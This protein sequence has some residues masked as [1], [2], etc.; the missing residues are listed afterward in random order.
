MALKFLHDREQFDNEKRA[1]EVDGT[2]GVLV[3]LYENGSFDGELSAD[4][5]RRLRATFPGKFGD[6]ETVFVLC[7]H[8]CEKNLQDIIDKESQ[9]PDWIKRV[10]GPTGI[11]ANIVRSLFALHK[12]GFVH[13]DVKPRNLMRESRN[14]VGV[15]LGK[16]LS[17]A[18]Q[19]YQAQ[20]AAE[21]SNA[22]LLIDCDASRRIGAEL[23]RKRSE[24]FSPPEALWM[25]AP[26]RTASSTSNAAVASAAGGAA[27]FAVT[28]PS[29]GAGA[30]VCGSCHQA[31]S[32][33][34]WREDAMGA[35]PLL[36][37]PSYDAWGLGCTLFQL[38]ALAPLFP[39]KANDALAYAEDGRAQLGVWNAPALVRRVK[40]AR[41]IPSIAVD[42]LTRLLARNAADRPSMADVLGDPFV[43]GKFKPEQ[44]TAEHAYDYDIFISYRHKSEF[45]LCEALHRQLTERGLSVFRDEIEIGL[46]DVI[47]DKFIK[48]LAST[49]IFVPLLSR[50]AVTT[51]APT[52]WPLLTSASAVDNVL[53]E[54]AFAF[55]LSGRSHTGTNNAGAAAGTGTVRSL[56]NDLLLSVGG[57]QKT[58][59]VFVG[60]AY[61]PPP[62]LP[63]IAVDAVT[64]EL[65][66]LA[67]GLGRPAPAPIAVSEVWAW[68]NGSSGFPLSDLDM[69]A[70]A[71]ASERVN[72]CVTASAFAETPADGERMVSRARAAA[73]AV[74]VEKLGV[75]AEKLY[76]IVRD[77]RRAGG[78]PSPR[79]PCVDCGR[80][81]R[82]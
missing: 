24:A 29:T 42:L 33:F 39:A 59:P 35:P 23:S 15:Q 73:S 74:A 58:A 25:A 54:H 21:D 13:G 71:A 79:A 1:R 41:S 47:R 52:S 57:L 26:A 53:L 12:A 78:S 65:A 76:N 14:K 2:R 16:A 81:A 37:D 68:L 4:E 36:A 38:L 43:T 62:A 32:A 72:D 31:L 5:A 82:E 63:A 55:E 51:A 46:G 22:V 77:A 56:V 7:M 64:A 11:F 66:S 69:Q 18:M 30:A 44:L 60:P 50:A 67:Q 70:M 9:A 17:Q 6:A 20:L 10:A 49:R 80:A 27:A 48:A 28:A 40:V 75:L 3:R 8:L 45:G 61:F 34:V 19:D